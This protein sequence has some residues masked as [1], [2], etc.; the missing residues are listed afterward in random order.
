MPRT[1][2]KSV[3]KDNDFQIITNKTVTLESLKADISQQFEKSSLS[4]KYIKSWEL[5]L[6]TL[7]ENKHKSHNRAT[8]KEKASKS[9]KSNFPCITRLHSNIDAAHPE[10][11]LGMM[12]QNKRIEGYE[13]TI[14]VLPEISKK[15]H[16][17]YLTECSEDLGER[18]CSR[19]EKCEC[20][21]MAQAH[22]VSHMGF[23]GKEF[24]LP[25]EEAQAVQMGHY[26]V[27]PKMCLLCNRLATTRRFFSLLSTSSES[28]E[29]LQDHR[30]RVNVEGEYALSDCVVRPDNGLWVGIVAPV[31]HHKRNNYTYKTNKHGKKYIKQ[32]K[33]GFRS[34]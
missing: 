30:V 14:P 22:G 6:N 16:E 7:I 33:L 29:L 5:H 26:P 8:F 15:Y 12:G 27:F 4:P 34:A 13:Y 2:R 25:C 10:S 31:V 21:R 11:L 19:G 23:I 32:T 17:K 3:D 20:L 9:T 24:L 1:K 28:N 18:R